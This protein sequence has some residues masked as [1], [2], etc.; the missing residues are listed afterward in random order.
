MKKVY[1]LTIEYDEDTEEIEYIVETVD[2]LEEGDI[3]EISMVE[4]GGVDLSKYFDQAVL[5]LI[6]ECY[7]IA[8][9]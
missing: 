2:R 6:A 4:V 8:E 9:A 3:P 1:H 7:E 5:K